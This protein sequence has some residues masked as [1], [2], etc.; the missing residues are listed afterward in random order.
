MIEALDEGVFDGCRIHVIDFA[1]DSPALDKLRRLVRKAC[2]FTFVYAVVLQVVAQH[3]IITPNASSATHIVCSTP[4]SMKIV[5]VIYS[6]HCRV[7]Y[8]QL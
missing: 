3:G 6:K 8:L 1:S 5:Q 7:L 4:T 2:K